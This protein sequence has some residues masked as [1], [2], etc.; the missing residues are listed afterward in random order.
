[1]KPV[2]MHPTSFLAGAAL[3]GVVLVATGALQATPIAPNKPLEVVGIPDPRDMLVIREGTPYIVPPEKLFVLTAVGFTSHPT[4]GVLPSS[5]S[6][7]AALLVDGAFAASVDA[8]IGSSDHW[9]RVLNGG[10]PSVVDVPNVVAQGG[11][12][13]EATDY[14]NQS[15]SARAWGYLIDGERSEGALSIPLSGPLEVRC[16]LDPR[17]LISF[18]PSF[19]VPPGKLLVVDACGGPLLIDGIREVTANGTRRL[20]QGLTAREGHVLEGYGSGYLIDVNYKKSKV[21]RNE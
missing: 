14:G 8:G 17:D 9:T 4:A 6:A 3:L 18:F 2:E 12:T 15:S 11:T 16:I 20:P 7:G 1:M 21:A 10:T 5:S 13:L 19:A